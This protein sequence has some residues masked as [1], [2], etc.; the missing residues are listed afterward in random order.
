MGGVGLSESHAAW[1]QGGPLLDGIMFGS[2]W[3]RN[4]ALQFPLEHGVRLKLP[5]HAWASAHRG[6]ARPVCAT[7]CVPPGLRVLRR[8]LGLARGRAQISRQRFDEESALDV[9]GRVI[10]AL[11]GAFSLRAAL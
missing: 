10:E 11:D 5:R 9:T 3:Y 4:K 8:P 1:Q 6:V 2:V 7:V